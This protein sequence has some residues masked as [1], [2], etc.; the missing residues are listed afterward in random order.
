MS[1][2]S[3]HDPIRVREDLEIV[4]AEEP[5]VGISFHQA[6]DD[7]LGVVEAQLGGRLDV[8]PDHLSGFV[9]DVNLWQRKQTMSFTG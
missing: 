9:V 2:L 4:R 8:V 6:E 3:C 1:R 7:L 5:G